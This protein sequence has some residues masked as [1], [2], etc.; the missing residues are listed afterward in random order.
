MTTPKQTLRE[1]EE[2]APG[3]RFQRLYRRRQQGRHATWANAAFNGG[4]LAV[5][6]A[7]IATYPIP[8]IPSE[9]VILAGLALISQGSMRGAKILDGTELRLRRVFAPALKVWRRWPKWLRRTLG[10][11]WMVLVSGLS[12]WA[13][14]ALSD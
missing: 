14:R 10:V 5:I 2:A 6:G 3:S 11:V 9:V 8:V 1:L 12:Y 7:G 13:Y 4:G